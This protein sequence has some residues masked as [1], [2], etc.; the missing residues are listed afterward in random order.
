[1]NEKEGHNP[2]SFPIEN[3][4]LDGI[5][6]IPEV[7]CRAVLNVD[8]RRET[9]P[10]VVFELGEGEGRNTLN[11]PFTRVLRVPSGCD[12]GCPEPL[13]RLGYQ[14]GAVGEG[15]QVILTVYGQMRNVWVSAAASKP[16]FV[17]FPPAASAAGSG[18]AKL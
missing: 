16:F 13:L 2:R 11:V 5:Q 15:I 1:M 3:M 4:T 10:V 8:D 9:V 18:P 6:L 12:L 7:R 17:L 14:G